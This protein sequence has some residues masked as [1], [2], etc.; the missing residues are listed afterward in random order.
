MSGVAKAAKPG[1]GGDDG[2]WRQQ[3]LS[4]SV[5][6]AAAAAP[7]SLSRPPDSGPLG[8]HVRAPE[9]IP[10]QTIT[11]QTI[12]CLPRLGRA[13]AAG[14]AAVAHWGAVVPVPVAHKT[15][16]RRW[17]VNESNGQPQEVQTESQQRRQQ[18]AWQQNALLASWQCASALGSC[19][20]LLPNQAM[21]LQ[22]AHQLQLTAAAADGSNKSC[23][24]ATH[25][26]S[27]PSGR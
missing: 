7:N 15:G 20:W 24:A 21:R 19:R 26:S 16:E 2:A 3:G 9:T 1:W 11:C 17:V 23:L 25:S 10:C 6:A 18:R 4:G 22:G 12:T 27:W 8:Q 13:E 14:V 5:M